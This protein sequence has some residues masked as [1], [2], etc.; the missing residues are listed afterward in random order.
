MKSFAIYYK[1][2]EDYK[3]ENLSTSEK[4]EGEIKSEVLA[5]YA[6]VGEL[7]VN[8]WKVNQGGLC[9]HP[10][11]YVDLGVKVSFKCES[12]RLYIPFK[13]K[14]TQQADLCKTI[15]DNRDLLCAVFNDEMLPKPQPNTCFCEVKNQTDDREFYLYQLG[16]DNIHYEAYRVD[17]VQV[18]TYVTLSLKGNP[19][20]DV[21]LT[22]YIDKQLYVRIRLCVEENDKFAITE[23]I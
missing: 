14:V 15:M 8:I 5:K 9:L 2:R 13:T 23:H 4:F 20:N 19:T 11:F 7:H 12:I 17:N 10:V 22:Q 3:S 21:D 1:I 6:D 18:G 16:S